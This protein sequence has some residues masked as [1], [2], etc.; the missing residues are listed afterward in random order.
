MKNTFLLFIVLFFGFISVQSQEY[1]RMID[2]STYSV[3]EIKKSAETYFA[4][5]EKG[6]GSGYKQYKRWEYMAQRLMNEKGYLPLSSERIEELESYNAYLNDKAINRASLNDNWLE[7]GPLDWNATS[8]W[9]PGVGRITG[10]AIDN[11]DN[12]H[13]LIGAN[14]GGVWK[15]TDGGSTWTALS[16]YFSNLRVYSVAIDPLNS[17][18]YFFGS[19]NGKIYK[20]TDSGATWNVLG[21]TGNYSNVNKILLHP[22]DSSLLFASVRYGGIYRSTDSGATWT[23]IVTTDGQGYD[24]E[25]KPNDT[26]VVYAAG[27]GFH[28]ST[29]GGATFTT[30]SG[31]D[32]GAK[33]IGVSPNNSSIVYVIDEDSGGFGGFYKSTDSGN[34]FTETGHTNRNYFGYDTTGYQSGGQAPRDMDIAVNPNDANEVHI[35]GILTWRSTDGGT[36]FTITSDWTPYNA[37]ALNVGYC[38]ADV[39]IM[40]FDNNTLFVG[41]DGGIFKATNTATINTSYYTDLTAGIGIRQFYKIGISQTTDVIVSGGSQDNGTSFYK[42]A[43]GWKDWLGADGMET[44]IDKDNNNT[45]YGTSQ[46]GQMYRSDNGGYSYTGLYEPGSG[47]GEWVTPFE[48]DPIDTNV[49]YLGYVNVYKSI[50]KGSSWSSISQNFGSNLDHLKVA[51]SDNNILFA[52]EYYKLYKT[53]DGGT[54]N[55]AQ[56]TTPGGSINSIAIHPSDPNKVAVATTGTNRVLVSTDG[57]MTWVNYKKNLPSFS[58]LALVWDDNGEDGLYLGMDYGIY[59]IDNTLTDWQPYNNNLPNVIINELEIN[60]LDNKIY[61]ASYGRGLWASPLVVPTIGVAS[62]LSNNDI[63][64]Y[65]NPAKESIQLLLQDSFEADLRVFDTSGKLVIYR[66]NASISNEYAIDIS[67]L[68]KGLYFLRINSNKG[69]L[70]K[71][72]VKN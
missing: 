43:T 45:M 9:N 71:K 10:I 67:T 6:R 8:G 18:N 52:A 51:P 53:T 56:I 48:Q 40:L 31:F 16:D 21:N 50:N 30:I 5:K 61:A 25:F 42:S 12:N 72:I 38:H 54:T 7:L 59:Y 68:S 70:T 34:S 57:G 37:N 49:I 58:A 65:P 13:I 35:A 32:G 36:N 24:I 15:T 33:M 3:A 39:D 1:L 69:V 66:P 26:N 4:D 20:S 19:N 64:I 11:S 62:F 22:T 47:G 17:N 28:K 46:F 55:W 60:S 27:Q 14:T 29:D 41:T 63:L 23:K 2:A 44:F